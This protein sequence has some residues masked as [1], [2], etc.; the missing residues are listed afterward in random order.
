MGD[1]KYAS[2]ERDLAERLRREAEASRPDFSEE[3]HRRICLVIEQGDAPSP[4][5]EKRAPGFPRMWATVAATL[6]VAGAVLLAWQS[7]NPQ[8]VDPGTTV[9]ET[10]PEAVA[11]ELAELSTVTQDTVEGALQ[12]DSHLAAEGW[13]H[14]DHDAQV[15]TELILDQLPLDMLASSK[16]P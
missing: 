3:L 10:S 2:G 9:E 7:Y 6:L 14:L 5:P 4:R 8:V 13:A 15:A 11:E 12:V 1:S 16:E